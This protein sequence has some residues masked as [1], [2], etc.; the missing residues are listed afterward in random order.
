MINFSCDKIHNIK[1]V[2]TILSVHFSSI[3][4]IH[5]IVQPSA[6]FSHPFSYLKLLKKLLHFQIAFAL[7]AKTGP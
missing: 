2:K 1:F 6:L 4:Y 3:N 5:N 7:E